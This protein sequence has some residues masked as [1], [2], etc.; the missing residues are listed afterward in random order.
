MIT[1]EG[2]AFVEQHKEVGPKEAEMSIVRKV[3][4]DTMEV[5][6]TS[7][8][9]YNLSFTSTLRTYHSQQS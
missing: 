7:P 8:P 4:G 6:G 1:F 9:S 5:V 2:G 3:N